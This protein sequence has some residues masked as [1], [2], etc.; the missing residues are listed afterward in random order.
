MTSPLGVLHLTT[1][2][3]GGAGRA[4]TDLACA[5]RAAGHGVTVVT[6]STGVAGYG[7]YADYLERLRGAGVTVHCWDSLFTR[8]ATLNRHVVDMLRQHV[9]V[10]SIDIIHAHAARPALIGRWFAA[11]SPHPAPVVQTQHGWGT[12][13][14]AVQAAADLEVLGSVARVIATSAATRRQL[15]GWGVPAGSIDV[16]PCGLPPACDA[17]PPLEAEET[18]TPLRLRGA[19]IGCVGSVTENKNQ[20]LLVD[21]LGLL[22]D[23]AVDAVFV[24]EGGEALAAYANA[25][26]IASRVHVAGYRADACRW[27]PLF[28][29]LVLPSRS[30]GQGLAVLEAFRAG[31]PVIASDIP[32]LA[33]LVGG[34]AH[35]DP[36]GFLFRSDD[37]PDLAGAIR[38]ALTVTP[39]ERAALIARARQTCA[40]EYTLALMVTRHEEL[41]ERLLRRSTNH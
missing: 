38:S 28:D 18:V 30:E 11:L 25:A 10:E 14:T 6:S 37:A 35:R 2:L 7:N 26:G 32:A 8:D 33:D 40:A 16:I 31:V 21:A 41:Y 13:K 27:L 12:S 19:V 24:G 34:D 4:I 1:F 20:R 22:G 23:V 15:A 5:Q 9:T 17:I 39:A 29:L 36:N 3:Q